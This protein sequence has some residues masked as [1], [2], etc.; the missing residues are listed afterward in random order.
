VYQFIGTNRFHTTA[1]IR[2]TCCCHSKSVQR[3][4]PHRCACM[5]DTHS[6]KSCIQCKPQCCCLSQLSCCSRLG[7][8]IIAGKHS[9]RPHL[10]TSLFTSC[11]FTEKC[12]ELQFCFDVPVTARLQW[13]H[14]AFI[15]L[16]VPLH[17]LHSTSVA[18][19]TRSNC[20]DGNLRRQHLLI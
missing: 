1:A 16:Q 17:S 19:N 6:A 20:C 9:C 3:G 11:I 8:P 18:G 12:Q 2:Q 7:V 15:R 13:P 5:E 4:T 10:G 14:L